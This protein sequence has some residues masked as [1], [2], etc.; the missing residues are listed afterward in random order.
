MLQFGDCQPTLSVE[1][2]YGGSEGCLMKLS[3]SAHIPS[4]IA[5]AKAPRAE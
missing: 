5:V 4:S 2:P 1:V 3:Q